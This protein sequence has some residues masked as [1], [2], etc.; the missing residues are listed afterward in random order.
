MNEVR[1]GEVP[2]LFTDEAKDRLLREF[3]AEHPERTHDISDGKLMK[4]ILPRARARI[5]FVICVTEGGPV[6]K[7]LC[8]DFP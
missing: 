5:H 3:R 6:I 8:R 2:T 1:L 7:T 4:C